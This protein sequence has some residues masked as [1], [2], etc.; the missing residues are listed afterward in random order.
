MNIK[1]RLM[2]TVIAALFVAAPVQAH[3]VSFGWTDNGDGTVTLWGEHWHGDIGTA[4]TANGG[5]TITSDADPSINFTA[6]WTG[7]QNNTN[8]DDMVADG[9]LTGYDTNT[10]N[11]GTYNDWM[12]TTPIVIGNGT[13][14]FFTGPNCC[15]DTMTTPV[16]ITLTGITSVDPGT[17]PGGSTA[18]PEPASL[19]L[20]GLGLVGMAGFSRR[21]RKQ[22]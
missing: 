14:N 6:Q 20:M 9:T 4:F 13:W 16:Q 5:I 8:R 12:F 7:V 1:L 15:I 22:I 17:G 19:A 18:V 2:G 3:L 21:K 10:G 11:S